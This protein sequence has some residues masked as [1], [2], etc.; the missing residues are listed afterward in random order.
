MFA[1]CLEDLFTVELQLVPKLETA[2]WYL[3]YVLVENIS[4]G[5]IEY[6]PCHQWIRCT[7]G[8]ATKVV[9][10]AGHSYSVYAKFRYAKIKRFTLDGETIKY[11]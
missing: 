2:N 7:Q 11:T 10:V 1:D 9:L 3:R 5:E 4:S 6:F 8:Q